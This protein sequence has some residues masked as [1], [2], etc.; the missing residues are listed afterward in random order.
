MIFKNP[1]SRPTKI[2]LR[3]G[4]L[5]L[6]ILAASTVLAQ[7][8]GNDGRQ[9]FDF[10]DLASRNSDAVVNIQL[11]AKSGDP[12]EKKETPDDPADM[13]RKFFE[14]FPGYGGKSPPNSP[15]NSKGSGF[16]YDSGGYIITNNHV[17]QG[18][19]LI[20]VS[21]SD[22]RVFTA[23]LIGTDPRSDIAVIKID[24]IDLP[25]VRI[26]DSGRMRVGEWVMAIG[27]PFGFDHTV[28][29]GI[30]SAK[31]RSLP[32]DSYVSFFQTDVPLNPG[33]SGGPLFNLNGEVIGVNSQI[34][35]RTGSFAGI[36]FA[37]PIN[38]AM[39]V[40]TQLRENGKVVR[41]WLGV[42]IQ[43]VT[44]E[45]ADSFSTGRPHGALVSK[46]FPDSPADKGGLKVGDIIYEFEGVAVNRS[47]D[48]P[49]MVGAHK[50]G[51]PGTLGVLR[52]GKNIRLNINIGE[53][54]D[55]DKQAELKDAAPPS[56]E[57]QAKYQFAGIT[58]LNPTPS[59]LK[60][61]NLDSG[62][63]VDS[64][65]SS[66]QAARAGFREGDMVLSVSGVQVGDIDGLRK[67]IDKARAGSHLAFLVS[68]GGQTSFLT[69]K[70]PTQ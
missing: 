46:V 38:L 56:P 68:R 33:N 11:K 24:A 31:Q 61:L 34:Y 22:R 23:T 50:A 47:G 30:I 64:L 25:V 2:S 58:F 42:T 29:K 12:E 10:A 7:A 45:L 55:D 51:T 36:S 27:S 54:P 37:I 52:R 16:I 18:D 62:A 20:E 28:T 44:S 66:G 63:K 60:K 15:P 8:P 14:G 59:E 32:S 39:N 4:G 57:S 1:G 19:H 48:L 65:T 41:G 43:E 17:I 40:A 21:L 26:G 3:M 6:L 70:K 53:L 9:L 67:V 13:F 5:V 69:L 35:T 49:P